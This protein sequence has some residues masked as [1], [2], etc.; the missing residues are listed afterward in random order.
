MV[1]RV[2]R[3]QGWPACRPPSGCSVATECGVR[4]IFGV[5]VAACGNEICG[6]IGSVAPIVISC[7]HC[8]QNLTRRVEQVPELPEPRPY[9]TGYAPTV[10]VGTWAVDPGPV[11]WI[12][13]AAISSLGCLVINPAD[14]L[15][16]ELHP[17]AERNSG[18]CGHDGLDGPNRLCPSC[19]AEVATLRDD[20]WS[21]VDL[22]FEPS[23]VDAIPVSTGDPA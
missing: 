9:G 22:R 11:G 4:D 7:R 8:G 19:H 10:P 14:G 2:C 17:E 20:C 23:A 21:F 5:S 15:D 3:F 12:R 16:L 6:R 18:C 13:D 1:P